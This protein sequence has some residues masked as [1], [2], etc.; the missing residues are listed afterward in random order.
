[1]RHSACLVFATDNGKTRLIHT[2]FISCLFL[3]E[4]HNSEFNSSKYPKIS[5]ALQ[6]MLKINR[7]NEGCVHVKDVVNTEKFNMHDSNVVLT[8]DKKRS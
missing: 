4:A 8:D 3:H 7:V 5:N 1:M 6:D 2:Q